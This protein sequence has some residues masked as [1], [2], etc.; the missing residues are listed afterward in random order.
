MRPYLAANLDLLFWSNATVMC[1]PPTGAP[2]AFGEV[3]IP[4]GR[5]APL[6]LWPFGPCAPPAPEPPSV[7][8]GSV[9]VV[10]G[11]VAAF[12]TV[13]KCVVEAFSLS[14]ASKAFTTKVCSP[15]ESVRVSTGIST[16]LTSWQGAGFDQLHLLTSWP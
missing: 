5:P 6:G 3:S 9:G 7:G 4:L 14:A 16:S 2:P 8:V 12:L 15:S 10:A 11:G 1:G 13:T